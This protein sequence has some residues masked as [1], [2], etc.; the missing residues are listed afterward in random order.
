MIE[1]NPDIVMEDNI[2][3]I[4]WAGVMNLCQN[5]VNQVRRLDEDDAFDAI[6][7]IVR[8]GMVPATILSHMLGI[9]RVKPI[10]WQTRDGI[11]LELSKWHRLEGMR[12]LVID[13]ILDSGLPLSQLYEASHPPDLLTLATPVSNQD[14]EMPGTLSACD[15]LSALSIYKKDTPDLWVSFP[16]EMPVS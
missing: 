1:T 15:V 9:P 2:M 14:A 7:P 13:D 11:Q 4:N 10:V 16:W 8:G 3:K 6:V 12:L 5:L